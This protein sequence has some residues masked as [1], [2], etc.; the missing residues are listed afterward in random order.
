MKYLS[1]EHRDAD[2]LWFCTQALIHLRQKKGKKKKGK[3]LRCVPKNL[4]CIKEGTFSPSWNGLNPEDAHLSF[5]LQNRVSACAIATF[6]FHNKTPLKHF[7]HHSQ[8]EQNDSYKT[9]CMAPIKPQH[10]CLIMSLRNMNIMGWPIINITMILRT[11]APHL[12]NEFS[13]MCHS[14]AVFEANVLNVQLRPRITASQLAA[15]LQSCSVHLLMQEQNLYSTPQKLLS[16]YLPSVLCFHRTNQNGS[17]CNVILKC[18][19]EKLVYYVSI[20]TLRYM[21]LSRF[22]L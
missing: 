9:V 4:K 6:V 13:W 14:C 5:S 12:L 20:N 2:S 19:Q 17:L 10:T 8:L 22:K 3:D 16:F 1:S 18:F 15:A 7:S 11:P 21:E